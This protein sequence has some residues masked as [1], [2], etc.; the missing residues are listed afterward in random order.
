MLQENPANLANGTGLGQFVSFPIVTTGTYLSV[1]IM[2][3]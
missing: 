3:H 2:G 1:S